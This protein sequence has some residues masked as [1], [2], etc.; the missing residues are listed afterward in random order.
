MGEAD[1]DVNC[2]HGEITPSLDN[3]SGKPFPLTIAMN[4]E[5]GD[6]NPHLFPSSPC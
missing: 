4:L 2:N 5:A 6:P 1:L 3:I